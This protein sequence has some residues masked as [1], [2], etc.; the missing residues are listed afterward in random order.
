MTL[1][2]IAA[3]VTGEHWLVKRTG[4]RDR[5]S[6]DEIARLAYHFFETHGRQHGR[7][8]DDW[9]AAEEE[10]ARHYR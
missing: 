2:A 1:E 3:S 6:R 8:V 5:S 10:L 7:D 9:L 4:G